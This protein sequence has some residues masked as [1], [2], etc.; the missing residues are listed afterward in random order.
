M[1]TNNL[2]FYK[3]TSNQP[4]RTALILEIFEHSEGSYK[5][6][7]LIEFEKPHYPYESGKLIFK[8]DSNY[9]TKQIPSATGDKT[10]L[11]EYQEGQGFIETTKK[12]FNIYLDMAQQTKMDIAR[13]KN[14][15]CHTC[16]ASIYTTP[17]GIINDKWFCYDCRIKHYPTVKL[18][19]G[20][21]INI[22]CENK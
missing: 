21:Q 8:Q 16:K 12:I 15:K 6:V 10:E 22:S 19:G 11:L 9:G 5:R 3:R 13:R 7:E 18:K 2:F 20:Y 4:N 14:M 17:L 1:K